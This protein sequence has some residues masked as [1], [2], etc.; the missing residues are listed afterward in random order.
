METALYIL[1]E[2]KLA[3]ILYLLD[4]TQRIVFD[5]GF[6]LV[7]SVLLSVQEKGVVQHPILLFILP[8]VLV[9]CSL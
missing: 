1:L 6:D 2:L 8:R 9:S 4:I 7:W 3:Y 5:V